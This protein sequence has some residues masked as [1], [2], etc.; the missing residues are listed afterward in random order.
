MHPTS[1]YIDDQLLEG[2]LD[3]PRNYAPQQ[4]TGQ[5]QAGVGVYLDQP[6]VQIRVDHEVHPEDFEVVGE[7]G[8]VD[9][10]RGRPD[11]VGCDLSHFGVDGLVEAF[12]SFF[13]VFFDVGAEFIVADLIAFFVLAVVWQVLL[14]CIVGQVDAS[15]VVLQRV[16]VRCRSDVALPVPV[17]LDESVHAGHHDVVAQVE[18]AFEVEEG[19]FDVGLDDEGAVGAVVVPFFFF[20]EGFD[21]FE[22]EAHFDSVSA[23]AVFSGFD[24][25][26]VV[27]LDFSFFLVVFGDLFGSLLVILQEVEVLLVVEAVLDVE[28]EGEVLEDVVFLLAVVVGHRV[29]QGFLVPQHVVVHQVVVHLLL[30]D[31]PRPHCRLVLEV[32]AS[33]NHPLVRVLLAVQVRAEVTLENYIVHVSENR[34]REVRP[35]VLLHH[36]V[37]TTFL[38]LEER[39]LLELSPGEVRFFDFVREGK[40]GPSGNQA[41][42]HAGVVPF[43][44]VDLHAVLVLERNLH[45]H[46]IG[47]VDFPN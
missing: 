37:Q 30:P 12:V 13:G 32:L 35:A 21:V 6:H 33:R 15:A 9:S 25:P 14:D 44:H 17:A 5:L 7:L 23:V 31:I 47:V 19:T 29:E 26:G 40:P 18:F 22:G 43:A 20:E 45:K 46:T 16:L 42:D 27:L 34:R 28:G 8:G 38:P 24:D 41:C 4:R 1:A 39:Q 3:H 10:S 36:V 2:V 11:G